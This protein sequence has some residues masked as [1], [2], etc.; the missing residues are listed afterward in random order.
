MRTLARSTKSADFAVVAAFAAAIPSVSG[1]DSPLPLPQRIEECSSH[2]I[3]CAIS[4]PTAATT[5]IRRAGSDPVLWS[6]PGWHRWLFVSNDG[7][8]AVV[9]YEGM[10]LVRKDVTLLEPVLTFYKRGRLTRRVTLGDLYQS[11]SQL[12]ETV[13]HL[14]W[15]TDITVSASDRIVLELVTGQKLGFEMGTGAPV[16]CSAIRC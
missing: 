6:I 2:H 12:R 7:Q 11:K 8:S 1:A 5:V 15:L 4:D 13:S 3:Y 9:G 16:N 14:N 10:N